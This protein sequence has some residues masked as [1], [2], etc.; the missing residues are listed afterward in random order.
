MPSSVNDGSRPSE[1]LIRSYSSGVIPCSAMISGVMAGTCVVGMAAIFLFS[2]F[3]EVPTPELGEGR[4]LPLSGGAQAPS[5]AYC[6]SFVAPV[7]LAGVLLNRQ[8]R[9]SWQFPG[10]PGKPAFGLLGWNSGNP[11]SPPVHPI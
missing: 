2:H 5:P 6:Y 7:P 11:P 8:F 1:A 10:V 9:R 3:S 4:D